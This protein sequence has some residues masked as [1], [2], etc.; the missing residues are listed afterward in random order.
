MQ[1]TEIKPSQR[2]LNNK[3]PVRSDWKESRLVVAAL[4]VAGTATLFATVIM[5]LTNTLLTNKLEKLTQLSANAGATAEELENVKKERVASRAETSLAITK[6]PFISGSVYPI[7]L[8]QVVIG[9]PASEILKRLPGAK[10]DDEERYLSYQVK[11][12]IGI[13]SEAAYYFDKNK[14]VSTI[15]YLFK[16]MALGAELV[17][18]TLV[19]NFGEPYAQKKHLSLWKIKDQEW[20]VLQEIGPGN[21]TFHLYQSPPPW[22]GGISQ[23]MSP[24]R[25]NIYLCDS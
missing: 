20:A 11:G 25:N 1:K 17:K 13:F 24:I 23:Q 7:G 8:D 16:D 22:I 14:K 9:T 4:S 5:P 19:T 18:K 2:R 10:W 21:V 15:L 12:T 3:L 6:S